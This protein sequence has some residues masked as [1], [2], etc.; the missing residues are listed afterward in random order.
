MKKNLDELEKKQEE[1]KAQ[2]ENLLNVLMKMDA[3]QKESAKQHASQL[4]KQKHDYETI[5]AGNQDEIKKLQLQQE[6]DDIFPF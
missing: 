1:Q 4:E 6:Q 2:N 3:E 5:L